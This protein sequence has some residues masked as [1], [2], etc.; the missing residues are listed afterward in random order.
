[1]VLLD[2]QCTHRHASG[3][4][5]DIALTMDHRFH[6]AIWS[7]GQWKDDDP[8]ADRRI[9]STGTGAHSDWRATRGRHGLD[10]SGCR[11]RSV[12]SAMSF[13]MHCYFRI[14]VCGTISSTVRRHRRKQRRS[15]D[16]HRLI[17]VL[18]I[19]PLLDR[20]IHNLSGGERQRIAMGR[21]LLSS[22]E[23]LLMDEP[24]ASLDKPLKSKVLTYLE[25]TVAEWNVPTLL[26]T[27]SKAEV[28]RVA[29]WV[30][31]IHEGRLVRE[32]RPR[33]ALPRTARERR[34]TGQLP[35]VRLL[36]GQSD[37]ASL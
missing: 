3:F 30:V 5:L 2:F 31:V 27:H 33:V 16:F 13:K 22:P 19:G 17:E 35:S 7:F 8:V 23:L 32:G 6:R 18:E 11:L 14:S 37:H 21:A 1:M 24:L 26:V 29:Q 10:G 28:R 12:R 15:V 36:L 34:P 4:A 9:S 25:R 20:P